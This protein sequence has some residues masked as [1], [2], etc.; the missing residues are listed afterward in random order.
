MTTEYGDAYYHQEHLADECVGWHDL[1]RDSDGERPTIVCLCGSTRFS[2]TFRELNLLLT[3][4]GQVVLSIGCDFKSDDDLATAGLLG[5][6]LDEVKARVDELHL[7]KIELADDVVV[8]DVGGYVGESTRA[9][10][11]HA[12][13]LGKPV[14]YLS[15]PETWAQA[16]GREHLSG[17]L[18]RRA[19]R[20]EAAGYEKPCTPVPCSPLPY[21]K[22]THDYRTA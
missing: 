2:D 19:L 16:P 6:D 8:I 21:G 7:R 9:E 18:S 3:L 14:A 17:V 10:V 11:A 22:G 1:V 20:R 12:E 4:S 15:R 5:S 13:K